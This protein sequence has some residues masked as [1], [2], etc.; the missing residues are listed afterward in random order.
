[1]EEDATVSHGHITS[2]A[3]LRSHRKLGL[4]TRLMRAAEH[5]MVECFDAEY[6][7]LHVRKSNR[8]A[9]HLYSETLGFKAR[10]P[11][12][13]PSRTPES[14]TWKAEPFP[15]RHKPQQAPARTP[16]PT[17][18]S[19]PAPPSTPAPCALLP[20]A[21]PTPLTVPRP[22]LQVNEIEAKYYADDEDAYDMRKDLKTH[23]SKRGAKDAADAAADKLASAT[24]GAPPHAI[25]QPVRTRWP[26]PAT[27][28]R[29]PPGTL[30]PRRAAEDGEE[31]KGAR[32]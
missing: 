20:S 23:P 22:P 25:A 29:A 28:R 12:G 7:S 3:V 10:T 31:E 11:P 24:L 18:P 19:R 26:L 15:A 2:L 17:L 5:D 4:A 14:R 30:T 32:G 9:F 6:V 27:G 13:T 16:A 21:V 8:A 1:M